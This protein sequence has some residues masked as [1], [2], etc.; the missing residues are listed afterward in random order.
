MNEAENIVSIHP[1][2]NDEFF[3]FDKIE[4]LFLN[5]LNKKSISNAYLFNGVKG[6]STID[7]MHKIY[8]RLNCFNLRH[9]SNLNYKLL[10]A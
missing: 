1:R 2:F 3:G 6:Y 10:Q 9:K 4:D 7:G 8:T 5:L